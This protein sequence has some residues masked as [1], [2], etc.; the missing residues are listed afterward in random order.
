[1]FTCKYDDIQPSE[2]KENKHLLNQNKTYNHSKTLAFFD[3]NRNTFLLQCS[4]ANIFKI[5]IPTR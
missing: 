5:R 3:E 1:M 2:S 4:Y